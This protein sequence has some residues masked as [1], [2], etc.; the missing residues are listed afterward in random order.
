L[1]EREREIAVVLIT[2][3]WAFVTPDKRHERRA[4]EV[5]LPA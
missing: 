1:R 3:G 5:E 4:K 2:G